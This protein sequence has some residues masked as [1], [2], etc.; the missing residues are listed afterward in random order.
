MTGCVMVWTA[1]IFVTTSNTLLKSSL[2]C[3]LHS[4]CLFV[5]GDISATSLTLNLCTRYL[6]FVLDKLNLVLDFRDKG[7][8]YH[9][10]LSPQHTAG[11]AHFFYADQTNLTKYNSLVRLSRLLFYI[12]LAYNKLLISWKANVKSISNSADVNRRFNY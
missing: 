5:V 9:C 12:M 11:N 3:S 6:H 1:C 2:H 4:F 8:L 7:E 10:S